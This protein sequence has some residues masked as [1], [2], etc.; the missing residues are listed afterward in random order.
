MKIHCPFPSRI[1]SGIYWSFPLT[2]PDFSLKPVNSANSENLKIHGQGQFKYPL[3]YLGLP[4]LASPSLKLE[5]G[6]STASLLIL[7]LMQSFPVAD[8]A[9]A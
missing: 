8:A 3:F 7:D 4:V 2:F 5:V 6:S 9:R 1:K